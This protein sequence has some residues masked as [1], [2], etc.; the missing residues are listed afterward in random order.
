MI[1]LIRLLKIVAAAAL[2]YLVFR[3]FFPRT[4]QRG[5]NKSDPKT[6]EKNQKA[7]EEMK[8]DPVCGTFIPPS[9]A[10]T[11]QIQGKTYYFCSDECKLKYQKLHK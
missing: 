5:S 10:V 1:I 3:M 9:Q 4:K 6:S 8:K 2:I 7:I 11:D